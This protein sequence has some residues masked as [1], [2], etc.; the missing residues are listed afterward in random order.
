MHPLRL[1]VAV[2]TAAI[3]PSL[4][5]CSADPNAP[6]PRSIHS[7]SASLDDA[8]APPAAPAAPEEKPVPDGSFSEADENGNGA[9]C[10]KATPSGRFLIKDDN[11]NTPSQ[12]CPPSYGFTGKGK[13]VKPNTEWADEDDNGN[14]NVCVKEVAAG[15]F[16]VKDD[17]L[18]TPSQPCPP[19]YML[20]TIG[21]GGGEI[22]AGPASEADDN[23]NGL[24]CIHIVAGTGDAIVK[25]DN[26]ATPS[27]PC[28]PSYSVEGVGKK[29]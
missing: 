9:V 6:Q 5:A 27:Q 1:A 7:V 14:G 4:I 10:V 3:V 12:P 17:N 19:A 28:A 26:L 18:A 2:A 24:V 20:T 23:L 15:R 21:R 16:I 25:D 11:L 13:G 29:K 8:A 22:P